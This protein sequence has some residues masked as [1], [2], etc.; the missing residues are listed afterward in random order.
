MNDLEV[1]LSRAIIYAGGDASRV[2]VLSIPDYSVTPFGKAYRDP[3]KT[4]LEINEYNRIK[5]AIT[6][7]LG[8]HFFNITEISRMAEEDES[9]LAPDK[10]HPSGVMYNEWVNL[11]LP[12]VISILEL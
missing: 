6:N 10:L 4:R 2:F 3:V 1:I 7:E 9:L 5:E 8:I 11:M 12:G